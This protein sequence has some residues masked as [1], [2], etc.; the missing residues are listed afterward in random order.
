M[1]FSLIHGSNCV[2][3]LV[4]LQGRSI[5]VKLADSHKG[6]MI[7]A[8]LS[9]AVVPIALP[10]AAGYPQQPGKPPASATPVAYTYPQAGATYPAYPGPPTGPAPYSSTA[11]APYPSQPQMP[12]SSATVM[13]DP[14]GLPPTPTVGMGGYP[15]YFAKQ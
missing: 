14:L 1:C 2:L 11:P 12:Y 6:K 10:L 15:Y 3:F 5:I 13:K 7:Q 8:Q 9:T 4:W